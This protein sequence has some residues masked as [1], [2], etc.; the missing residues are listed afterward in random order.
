MRR[1]RSSATRVARESSESSSTRSYGGPGVSHSPTV[2]RRRTTVG[3]T[4]KDQ[5]QHGDG[6]IGRPCRS[7]LRRVHRARGLGVAGQQ[8]RGD[9]R[10]YRREAR[11]LI[12]ELVPEGAEVHTAKV[13]TLEDIGPVA[14]L[15][16]SGALRCPPT[17][18]LR[19]AGNGEKVSTTAV[20]AAERDGT[21][22]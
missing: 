17:A 3:P 21:A 4:R 5:S 16:E 8:H 6:C 20:P 14:E 19:R 10:R 7:P 11:H 18:L 9:R 22:W 15:Q 13:K 2:Q 12:V 1:S